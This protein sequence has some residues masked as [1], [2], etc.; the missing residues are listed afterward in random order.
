M[1]FFSKK[2]ILI[3]TALLATIV[4]TSF[5]IYSKN[6][7]DVANDS[8]T[9]IGSNYHIET[10]DGI[11]LDIPKDL[12][13]EIKPV[14]FS[15]GYTYYMIT[16]KE[17]YYTYAN[18][19][20]FSIFQKNTDENYS[21]YPQY[22]GKLYFYG[23]GT[24]DMSGVH[25]G[26]LRNYKTIETDAKFRNDSMPQF[27]HHIFDVIPKTG[28]SVVSFGYSRD[29]DNPN[30]DMDKVWESIKNSLYIPDKFL[31]KTYGDVVLPVKE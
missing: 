28:V 13:I 25:E 3:I 27:T 14:I 29:D 30:Q 24:V 17:K 10:K 16:S 15:N 11:S 12:Q 19:I 26:K 8:I 6:H 2:Y 20:S 1:K 5:W 9:E 7:L 4:V 18:S 31:K 21:I 23:D 22:P